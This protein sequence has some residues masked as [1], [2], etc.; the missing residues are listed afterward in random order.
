MA[1]KTIPMMTP[2]PTALV[3]SPRSW[4]RSVLS[5]EIGWQMA[6]EIISVKIKI[7]SAFILLGEL[8]SVFN[9]L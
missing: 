2:T 6:T 4:F 9:V 7:V 1:P 3:T 8:F 5:W